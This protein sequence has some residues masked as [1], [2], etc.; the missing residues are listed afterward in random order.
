VKA[1]AQ[2]GDL[3]ESLLLKIF[4]SFDTPRSHLAHGHN[5]LEGIQ[6]IETLWQLRKRDEVT[7]NVRYL[8]LILIAHI[9]EKHAISLIE[10]L[11]EFFGLDFRYA[12]CGPLSFADP[13]KQ[14]T[15]G[16]WTSGGG[17]IEVVLD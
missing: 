12:H 1:A 7:A 15:T 2:V 11:F 8:I 14:K 5:L 3:C 16:H 4:D 10:S 17:S 6:F 13:L 9:Q